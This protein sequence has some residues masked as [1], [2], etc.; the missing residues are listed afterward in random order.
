MEEKDAEFLG[1]TGG[2]PGDFEREGTFQRRGP[3]FG[4]NRS[5]IQSRSRYGDNR[6][7]HEYVGPDRLCVP[8]LRLRARPV[9]HDVVLSNVPVIV[10]VK[11][12]VLRSGDGLFGMVIGMILGMEVNRMKTDG[13]PPSIFVMLVVKMN[14]GVNLREVEQHEDE[15]EAGCSAYRDRPS[16]L[17]NPFFE[18]WKRILPLNEGF[19]KS[20]EKWRVGRPGRPPWAK[21]WRSRPYPSTMRRCC[22][23]PSGLSESGTVPLVQ[24]APARHDPVPAFVVVP[25]AHAVGEDEIDARGVCRDVELV[26]P[27][28]GG[29]EL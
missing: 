10:G 28:G 15:T 3:R 4:L 7:R 17:T 11:R 16:Q 6:C 13:Q 12:A 25:V 23:G 26:H 22:T 14:E 27:V 1:N 20:P 21:P 24:P 8:S 29:G 9:D 5:R 19:F 2:G 18:I